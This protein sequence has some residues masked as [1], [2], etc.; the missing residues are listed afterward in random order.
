MNGGFMGKFLWVNLTTGA[1]E[2]E[3]PDISLYKD[4]L[5]GYGIGDKILYEK[6][7]PGIDP[8]G[9][10]NILAY[11]PGLLTG[12]GALVA[13]RFMVVSKSPLTGGI[14]DAN[15]GGHIGAEMKK[16]G[17][18]GIYF[19]GQSE[20]P[21]Y[22]YITDDHAEL[23]DATSYWGMTT[24][25]TEEALREVTDPKARVSAIGPAGERM[26]LLA[27]IVTE[28]GNVA[29]RS[30]LGAVMGSKK[31]KAVV[32]K[33]SQKVKIADEEA[34]KAAR[35]KYTPEFKEGMGK[36]LRDFG[37]AAFYEGSVES[38]DAP[39]KNWGG[40]PSDYPNAAKCGAEALKEITVK[41]TPCTG[42]PAG[43]ARLIQPK[44]TDEQIKTIQYESQ[45][46][47][48]SMCLVDDLES[49]VKA[50]DYCN[51]YGTDTISVGAACAFAIECFENG[52]L[53]LEQTD[54]LELKWGNGPAMAE[55]ARRIC[56][57]ETWLGELLADG[58]L[59]A[60]E[61]IPGSFEYAMQIGG[62]ELPMHDQR[63]TYGLYTMYLAEPTPG[64]HTQGTEDYAPPQIPMPEY[65]PAGQADRGASHK[66]IEDFAHVVDALGFCLFTNIFIL[67]YTSAEDFLN[68]VT[69][70]KY[71]F[72]DLLKIGDRISMLRHAFNPR[73]GI[74]FTDRKVP[75]RLLKA[76]EKE[77]PLQGV[78]LDHDQL[79]GDYLKDSGLDPVTLKPKKE[80]LLA[81]GLDNV[82]SE[83][84]PE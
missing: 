63:L 25:E 76:P 40:V 53:T 2:V 24:Y 9:P 64:K 30:G 58:T 20:K 14:G 49:M 12:T 26:S 34:F 13:S 7:K 27:A 56:M 71:T 38:A 6:L 62:Q 8:L 80:R 37:T 55:L 32:V 51:R 47:F 39:I 19:T 50:N 54:G 35:A 18:D 42:C 70:E 41:K 1:I 15:C 43:C 59:K 73:E 82:A 48:G 44:Y 5:G 29:A 65:D 69:G 11:L 75:K 10:E 68:A 72:E 74:K 61:Q 79:I 83:L 4:Y 31:L 66:M 67:P 52:L 23:R 45:G 21:V 33:G 57:R 84:Y 78:V 60:T 77:G 28:K 16:A 36:L 22:L 3:K 81:L 46:A 17:F